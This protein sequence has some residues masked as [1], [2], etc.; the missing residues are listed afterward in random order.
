MN[1]WVADSSKNEE[2]SSIAP[3]ED[4]PR[5]AITQLGASYQ[6]KDV[7]KSKREAKPFPTVLLA[8]IV[9]VPVI[10]IFTVSALSGKK[11]KQDESFL[12]NTL[13]SE[14]FTYNYNPEYEA[15]SIIDKKIPFLESHTLK[16]FADGEKTLTLT[17]KDVK[18]DYNLNESTLVKARRENKG[19]YDEKDFELNSKRGLYFAKTDENFEHLVVLV[20]RNRNVLY[21]IMLFSTT[22]FANDSELEEEFNQEVLKSITFL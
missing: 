2:V 5:E 14:Y 1:D 21:E 16:S 11:G 4:R 3:K 12:F 8:L 13:E 22:N 20:D 10:L 18:F 9:V 6:I 19:I 7:T 17:V 15:Q